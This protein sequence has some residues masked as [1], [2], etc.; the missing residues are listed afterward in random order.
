ML[1]D[2]LLDVKLC[3][4][5]RMKHPTS[6]CCL[7]CTTKQLQ[8][9]H[10]GATRT[11]AGMLSEDNATRLA[12]AL[13]RMRGAALKIGQM[14]SMQDDQVLPPQVLCFGCLWGPFFLY[15]VLVACL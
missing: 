11:D 2:Y 7:C 3:D 6:Y 12:D 9:A 4:V 8:H 14:L 13:C 1:Q 5:M 10:R 15:Y